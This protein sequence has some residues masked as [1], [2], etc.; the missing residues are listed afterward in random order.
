MSSSSRRLVGALTLAFGLACT[1]AWADPSPGDVESAKV[2]FT[3][4]LELRGKNDEAGA[5]PHFKAAY[6]LVP[7]P[8]TGLELGRT[9]LALGKILEGRATLLEAAGMLKKPSESEKAGEAREEAAKLADEAKGRLASLQVAYDAP[10]KGTITL[11]IDDASIPPDAA[12]APRVVN[13]G[14]HVIVARGDGKVARAE[15]DVQGGEQRAVPLSFVID[16]P[17]PPPPPPPLGKLELS[18]VVFVGF[19][20]AAAGAVVGTATGI[21]AFAVTSTVKNECVNRV[22]PA[23]AAGD[24]DRSKALGTTA[25]ISFVIAGAGAIVGII[26]LGI[27]KRRPVDAP[28]TTFVVHPVVGPGILGLEGTF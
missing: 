9:Q 22:C 7:S 25:T 18:P 21:A 16:A 17:P 6:A 27:S 11:T 10:P 24:I 1:P 28:K 3:Q 13:P 2:Q 8:I 14:H 15:V 26:G 5:L 19:G 20:I 23:S 4:G 12:T